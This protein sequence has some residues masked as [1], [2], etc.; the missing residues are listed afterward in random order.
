VAGNT[1]DD[2]LAKLRKLEGSSN[3]TVINY[4]GYLGAYQMGEEALIEAGLYEGDTTPSIRDWQGEWTGKAHA[5]GIKSPADFI[6]AKTDKDGNVVYEKVKVGKREARRIAQDPSKIESARKAQDE[7]V[8]VYHKDVW[9]IICHYQLDQH[10]GKTYNGIKNTESGLIAG[11]HLVGLGKTYKSGIRRP[12]LKD[13]LEKKGEIIPTDGKDNKGTPIT[14]YLEML[15]GYDV[16][17]KVKPRIQSPAPAR[18]GTSKNQGVSSALPQGV[19]PLQTAPNS[20]RD[21]WPWDSNTN[22]DG[23]ADRWKY[24]MP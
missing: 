7:A 14:K 11:Y 6:G 21:R 4:D 13:Y 5:M 18:V 12:G 3:Y 22:H 19:A 16:P 24:M 8:R 15:G 23:L 2:F 20:I 1:Y 10:V 17:F 9:R